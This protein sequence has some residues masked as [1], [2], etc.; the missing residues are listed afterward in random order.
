MKSVVERC[1]IDI[2]GD[3]ASFRARFRFPADLEVFRGHFPGHPIVPGVFLL[4]AVRTAAERVLGPA[5]RIVRVRD[6]KFTSIV[7]PDTILE[8]QGSIID[9]RCR[10][11]WTGGSRVDIEFSGL[12][13]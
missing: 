10:A 7:E 3:A 11:G 1:L 4:E 2:E 13:C 12:D 9:N 5:L 8:L 6:A